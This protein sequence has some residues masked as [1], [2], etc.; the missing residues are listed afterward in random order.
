MKRN[1][2]ADGTLFAFIP[3]H[4]SDDEDSVL[5]NFPHTVL[6]AKWKIKAGK[7]VMGYAPYRPKSSRPTKKG[8][9]EYFMQY[10]NKFGDKG[11]LIIYYDSSGNTWK[12]EKFIA[13][14][15]AGSSSGNG[16]KSFFVHLTA[17]GLA[18]G[19]PCMHN[20]RELNQGN[21]CEN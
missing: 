2:Q 8:D 14:E 17:L 16:W 11:E 5:Y 9:T 18:D 13:G 19:E 10:E 12:G 4:L 6:F 21:V 15:F 1:N 3:K 20:I 7:K